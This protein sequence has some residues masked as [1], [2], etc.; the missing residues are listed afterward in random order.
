M[1]PGFGLR[2]LSGCGLVLDRAGSADHHADRFTKTRMRETGE[3]ERAEAA[4]VRCRDEGHTAD[5][6]G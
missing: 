3:I 1:F 2:V 5:E 4:M 6:E